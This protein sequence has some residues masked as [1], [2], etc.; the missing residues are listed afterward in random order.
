MTA[1]ER[2]RSGFTVVELAIVIGVLIVLAA[3]LF[4][5]IQNLINQRKAITTVETLR[6]I[7]EGI[8]KLYDDCGV[9]PKDG[10]LDVLWDSSSTDYQPSGSS[11]GTSLKLSDCWDGPY[12]IPRNTGGNQQKPTTVVGIPTMLSSISVKYSDS[13]TNDNGLNHEMYLEV[14]NVPYKVALIIE[15]KVDGPTSS[16]NKKGKWVCESP[17]GQTI[18]SAVTC[19]YIIYEEP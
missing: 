14:T 12:Y 17:S 8:A 3:L 4:P 5:R 10:T 13:D 6:R 15:R 9:L 7:A 19:D 2:N 11:G 1:W 18:G 16:L